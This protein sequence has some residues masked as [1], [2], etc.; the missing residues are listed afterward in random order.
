M[1]FRMADLLNATKGNPRPYDLALEQS[2]AEVRAFRNEIGEV[3]NQ[4]DT[5]AAGWK[6]AVA[7]AQDELARAERQ[8]QSW[9]E[10]EIE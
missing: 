7:T 10:E 9:I 2:T 4:I 8:L 1:S 6:A 3:R 5:L